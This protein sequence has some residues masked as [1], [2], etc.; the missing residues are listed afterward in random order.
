MLFGHNFE[1]YT[2]LVTH[3]DPRELFISF[4]ER[5][6]TNFWS[7]LSWKITIT[8]CRKILLILLC[9]Y[10]IDIVNTPN[11]VSYP[12]Y[13][14]LYI[15][16]KSLVI[17]SPTEIQFWSCDRQNCVKTPKNLGRWCIP[18]NWPP[19][20]TWAFSMYDAVLWWN[21]YILC[22]VHIF[23]FNKEKFK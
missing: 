20:A 7:D 17:R 4:E 11:S 1:K 15:H 2:P 23:F 22:I 6:K 8:N 3:F 14:M 18:Q 12:L 19:T 21:I 5:R 16:G 13:W 10:W 9:P